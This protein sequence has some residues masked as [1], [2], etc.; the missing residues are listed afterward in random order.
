[1]KEESLSLRDFVKSALVDINDAVKE[2]SELGVAI[3]YSEYKS[4]MYPTLKPVEFDVA[5]QVS[6]N[7]EAGKK[8][9]AGLGLSIANVSFGKDKL[10]S[11]EHSMTN[12]IKF[13]VDV[14]LGLENKK[15]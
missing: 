10:D 1:M 15:D 3:A 2:A 14:F 4:G 6:Q 9:G 8:S 11:I 5:V 12:R 13:S 7:S